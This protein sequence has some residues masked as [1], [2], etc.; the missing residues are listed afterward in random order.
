MWRLYCHKVKKG[1]HCIT[2]TLQLNLTELNLDG[3]SSVRR[4]FQSSVIKTLPCSGYFTACMSAHFPV[5]KLGYVDWMTHC[6]MISNGVADLIEFQLMPTSTTA[7]FD[8]ILVIRKIETV[9]MLQFVEILQFPKVLI[10]LVWTQFKPILMLFK[11][12]K[13]CLGSSL[14]SIRTLL[15]RRGE[16]RAPSKRVGFQEEDN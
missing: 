11:A 4:M 6:G 9:M 16:L 13:F 1:K 2:Y 14:S 3:S 15:G 12:I 5:V 10:S 8:N 7:Y